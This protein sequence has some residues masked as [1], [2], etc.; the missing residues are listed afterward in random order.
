MGTARHIVEDVRRSAMRKTRRK[1][2]MLSVR[3]INIAI[4]VWTASVAVSLVV[5]VYWF[6]MDMVMR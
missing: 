2:P 3:M 6:Y 1:Q 5:N 4:V